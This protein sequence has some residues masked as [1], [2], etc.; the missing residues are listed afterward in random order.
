[1]LLHILAVTRHTCLPCSLY[2]HFKAL[3]RKSSK[4]FKEL[5]GGAM[6]ME[7][8]HD[9]ESIELPKSQLIGEPLKEL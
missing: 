4:D 9:M 3:K 2:S 8:C 1:M 7:R 5:H 6:E